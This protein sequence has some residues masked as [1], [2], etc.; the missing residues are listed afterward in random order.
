MFCHFKMLNLLSLSTNK[1]ASAAQVHL[2]IILNPFAVSR[3]TRQKRRRWICRRR[4]RASRPN[5]ERFWSLLTTTRSSTNRIARTSTWRCLSWPKCLKTV[6]KNLTLVQSKRNSS[7]WGTWSSFNM[8]PAQLQDHTSDY[9]SLVCCDPVWGGLWEFEERQSLPEAPFFHNYHFFLMN[10]DVNAYRL[11]LEGITV[12][13]K[14]CPKPIKTWVQCGVSMKILN[15]LKKWVWLMNN[16]H[17]ALRYPSA[18][19]EFC[20]ILRFEV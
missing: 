6:S 8:F 15:S 16:R 19:P 1:S 20:F 11:E 18:A 2:L 4:W 14:G 12:K 3:S 13:G 7:V 17:N 5:R 10:P 9:C